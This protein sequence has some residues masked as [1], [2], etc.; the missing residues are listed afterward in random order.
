M[1]PSPRWGFP[2]LRVVVSVTALPGT[3]ADGGFH[4]GT[5]YGGMVAAVGAGV[6]VV[7]RKRRL[8]AGGG[9]VQVGVPGGRMRP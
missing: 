7:E 1:G 3:I 6:V 4:C 9:G 8:G 5:G 2:H